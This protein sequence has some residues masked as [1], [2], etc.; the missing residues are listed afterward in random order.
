M[1]PAAEVAQ[2][3]HHPK[4]VLRPVLQNCGRQFKHIFVHGPKRVGQLPPKAEPGRIQLH[5]AETFDKSLRRAQGVV[6][7]RRA[8]QQFEDAT[9]AP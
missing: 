5:S 9:S 2:Q 4:A 3:L 1:G 6:P 7:E 8:G